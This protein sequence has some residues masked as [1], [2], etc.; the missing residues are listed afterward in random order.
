[1]KEL[2]KVDFV[3]KQ[4]TFFL[5]RMWNMRWWKV[6]SQRERQI[7]HGEMLQCAMVWLKVR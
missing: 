2:N 3:N 1:M 6:T 7:L 4:M 5:L